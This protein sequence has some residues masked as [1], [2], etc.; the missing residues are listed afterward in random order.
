LAVS[1]D[2]PSEE[3]TAESSP[4]E[5]PNDEPSPFTALEDKAEAQEDARGQVST[6]TAEAPRLDVVL[7]I[8]VRLSV[9]LGRTEISIREVVNLGRG[10]MIELDRSAGEPLDVRVNG[11]L[12]GRGEVVVINEDR[13]GLR[14]TEVVSHAERVKRLS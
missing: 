4:A 10:S 9:E 7:D 8:P 12:I 3:V 11:V 2:D 5:V 6:A 13:L 1:S 14:F